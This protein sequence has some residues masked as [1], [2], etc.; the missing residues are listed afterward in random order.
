[1]GVLSS[2]KAEL[3]D[4]AYLIIDEALLLQLVELA[5]SVVTN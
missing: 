3:S 4:Q 1:M 5:R 2:S